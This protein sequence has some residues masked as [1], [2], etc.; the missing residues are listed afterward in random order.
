MTWFRLAAPK[1]M[2]GEH[3]S[4]T[5]GSDSIRAEENVTVAVGP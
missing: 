5:Q 2:E 3:A 4:E 1:H